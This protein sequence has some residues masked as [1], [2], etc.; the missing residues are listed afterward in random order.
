[1][2]FSSAIIHNPLDAKIA[3]P[4]ILIHVQAMTSYWINFSKHSVH[5][6]DLLG[7]PSNPGGVLFCQGFVVITR[8]NLDRGEADSNRIEAAD[9][10]DDFVQ[11]K[12]EGCRASCCEASRKQRRYKKRLTDELLRMDHLDKD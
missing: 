3:I 10:L 6:Y 8:G 7:M 9:D 5:P 2:G 4:K 12:R 11:Y 1:M